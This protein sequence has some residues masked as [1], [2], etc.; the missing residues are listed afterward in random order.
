MA[1]NERMSTPRIAAPLAHSGFRTLWAASTLSLL[2][3]WM[4]E[5]ACAWQMR[6]MTGADP[7]L[8][9]SVYTAL[10]LPIVL[11]VIPAGVVTDLFDR[12]RV[13]IWTH[14]WLA[15]S[16][17]LLAGLLAT[18]YMT[19]LSLL[20]LLPLIAM[21]Q[22][23]RMPGISTLIPDLVPA[24]QLPAA[25]SLNSMAQTGSRILGPAAAGAII[26]AAGVGLV[27]SVNAA[28]MALIVLLFVSLRYV[29]ASPV[30]ASAPPRFFAAIKEGAVFAA[31]TSWKRNILVRLGSFFV[32]G[33]SVPALMAVRFDSSEVYG[34]MY[35]CFGVGSLIGL[36]VIGQMGHERLDRRVSR[37]LLASAVCIV[38]SGAT[39][40]PALAGPLLAGVGASW[41]FCTNSL[42][43]AAQTQLAPNM[44]GRGLSFVYAVGTA[45]LACGGLLWGAIARQA[46][47]GIALAASGLA[48]MLLVAATYRMSITAGS[49]TPSRAAS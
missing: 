17:A 36:L 9:A 31:S 24:R 26:A 41:M 21:G 44:R 45:C 2:A 33:A 14:L 47:P 34:L 12:R 16:L 23:L 18:E 49:E 4:T 1:V 29:P 40:E 38:L 46:G 7:L 48:L 10:Q 32:C 13:M 37:G 5:V 15:L 19:P 8:V 20:L 35:G 6:L 39:D 43:V 22:A 28:I 30:T 11:L 27:L 42:M 3:Y 25:V